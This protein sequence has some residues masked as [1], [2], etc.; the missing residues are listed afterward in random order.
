MNDKKSK[1]EAALQYECL[2]SLLRQFRLNTEYYTERCP[3]LD[4]SERIAGILDDLGTLNRR[5]E[6]NGMGHHRSL[7]QRIAALEAQMATLMP[8]TPPSDGQ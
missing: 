1:S 8:T 4:E 3:T 7:S 5:V 2:V 6:L